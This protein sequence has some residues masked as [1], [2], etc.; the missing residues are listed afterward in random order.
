MPSK[1]KQNQKQQAAAQ[2]KAPAVVQPATV[3]QFQAHQKNQPAKATTPQKQEKEA[4]K[5][6]QVL[7]AAP[8]SVASQPSPKG[9]LTKQAPLTPSQQVEKQQILNILLDDAGKDWK[10]RDKT[11]KQQ[12]PQKQA[13]EKNNKKTHAPQKADQGKHAQQPQKAPAQ[14][15]PSQTLKPATAPTLANRDSLS[16]AQKLEQQQILNIL[17]DDAG[18]DWKPRDRTPKQP[19]PKRA[20][21]Q[22][23]GKQQAQKDLGKQKAQPVA[24]Q[25]NP[26]KQEAKSAAP[27]RAPAQK[28][29]PAQQTQ[30]PTTAPALVKRA[31]LS[32]AQQLEQQQILNI[33]LD[34][35]GK[36]WKPR[37]KK[38][39]QPPAKQNANQMG[40]GK[41]APKAQT[42]PSKSQAKSIP[43][44]APARSAKPATGPALVNRAPLSQAQ[45]LELQ[46]ILN[47]LLDDDVKDWKPRDKT[48]KQPIAKKNSKQQNG[49]QTQKAPVKQQTQ[50]AAAQNAASAQKAHQVQKPA[51]AP[52]LVKCAP[53]SQA[54]Q[55]EQQQILNILLDDAGKDW[56]PR[57]QS[58]WPWSPKASTPTKSHTQASPQS[59][60]QHNQKQTPP[61]AP[62][63]SQPQKAVPQAKHIHAKGQQ[64]RVKLST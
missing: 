57:N 50:K 35:A 12:T 43:Q 42:T 29:A 53:L 17:L 7:K 8:A 21:K 4:S 38:L 58:A 18:K 2:Q 55:L 3:H 30:R 36:D 41:Q 10:P 49:K 6:S 31:S 47:I 60:T 32:Q 59:K 28:A 64:G 22:K 37:D 44:S 27:H 63:S 48:P 56:K 9:P 34:D 61:K 51:T 46:Q 24:M 40:S 13:A 26:V 39:K 1:S 45:Q 20:S 16:Q 25:K 11:P 62:P 14:K 52:S 33:L 19:V 5:Q 54:Q 15:A 23:D